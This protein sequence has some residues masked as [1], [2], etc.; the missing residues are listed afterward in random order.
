MENKRISE[1]ESLEIITDMLQ[2]SKQNME[3]GQGNQFLIYGYSALVLSIVVF[4]VV[5]LT[6]NAIWSAL[7]FLMFAPSIVLKLSSRHTRPS[8]VT[9]IDRAIA[10]TW[11]V[12]GSLFLLT[13][14]VMTGL[15]FLIGSCNFAL[16]LPLSLIY[17]SIGTSITG[18]ILRFRPLILL[19]FLAF[20]IALYM[21]MALT[22]G[23]PTQHSWH[24]L[25]G[26]AFLFM[27]ILPGHILNSKSARAC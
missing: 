12:T 14:A 4:C 25:F 11:S 17:A 18:V 6:G 23:Q 8:V 20:A 22:A 3:V 10:N 16:M 7:W 13:I 21:L 24:L 2:Q 27:M 9:Y 1:K 26:A 15:A 5:H 19:P